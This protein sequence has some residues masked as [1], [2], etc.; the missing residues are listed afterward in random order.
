MVRLQI[1]QHR[2][3]FVA[4]GTSAWFN[5]HW[6][7]IGALPTNAL[8]KDGAVP[9]AAVSEPGRSGE[10]AATVDGEHRHRTRGRARNVGDDELFRRWRSESERVSVGLVAL[11]EIQPVELPLISKRLVRRPRC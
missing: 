9:G 1:G 2:L 3:R 10:W 8:F 11:G 5:C 7:S 4:L 6:K